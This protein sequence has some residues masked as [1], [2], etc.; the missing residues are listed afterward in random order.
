MDYISALE[1]AKL[2]QVKK[3]I[4]MHYDT[5][6]AIRIDQVE[7]VNYFKTNGIELVLMKIGETE[8]F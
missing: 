1:A 5:F 4:G 8:R 6:D 3:V 2:L 7:V